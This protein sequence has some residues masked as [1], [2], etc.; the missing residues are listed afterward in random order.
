MKRNEE[1]EKSYSRQPLDKLH[2]QSIFSKNRETDRK[3]KKSLGDLL[4][5]PSLPL[6]KTDIR[7]YTIACRQIG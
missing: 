3:L 7:S 4:S 2:C 5:L 6:S 1:R